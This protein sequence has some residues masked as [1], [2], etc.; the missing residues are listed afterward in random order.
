M[1]GFGVG[2]AALLVDS[3]AVA[4]VTYALVCALAPALKAPKIIGKSF[5][6][7]LFLENTISTFGVFPVIASGASTAWQ[8]VASLENKGYR[9]CVVRL[10]L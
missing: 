6:L 3:T 5:R 8:S 2:F 1:F 7:V 9:S 4:A 10:F